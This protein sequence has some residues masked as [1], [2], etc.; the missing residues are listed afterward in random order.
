MTEHRKVQIEHV[1]FASKDPAATHRFVEKAFGIKFQDMG[2][3][4]GNYLMHGS[5]EGAEHTSIGL[6]RL[7]AKENPGTVAYLT[8]PDIDVAL[9]NVEG[10]GGKIMMG[11]TE[12][13]GMGWSAVIWAPGD[14]VQGLYQMK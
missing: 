6:R 7:E 2:T 13:P 11:K 8:V 9:K 5:K 1:E 12:I 10:A 3:E 4:M 14:V